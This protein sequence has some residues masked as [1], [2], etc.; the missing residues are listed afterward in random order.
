MLQLSFGRV[1]TYYSTKWVI[2]T[3]VAI[4]EIGS[5]ICAT[6]P[7]SVVLIVGR[8][9]TG[10]GGAGV[11]QGAFLLIGFLVPMEDR[12]KYLG[13]LG[14]VFGVTS[15]LGPIL[16]GYL[17]AITWRWCFW[18]NLPVGGVAI[19]LLILLTP[20]SEPPV[21]RAT[22]WKGRFLELDPLGFLLIA[23]CL[24]CLLLAVLF[25]GSKYP[26]HSGTIIALFVVSGVFGM[27][28]IVSQIW[29]GEKATVPPHVIRQRSI[30]FGCIVS[31]GIGSV[32]V[33][34]AFYL[35]IWFQVIQGKSPQS[36][37]LSLIPLLLSVVVAVI[38]SGIF[39][40]VAGYY[41]PAL[42]IGSAIL[43]VGAGLIST[44]S[45]DV[46]PRIWIRYQ[47]PFINFLYFVRD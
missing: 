3:N 33:V 24:V 14:S 10:I 28:F 5:I 32:L 20:N 34:F 2:V 26:W 35:P 42:I 38:S 31:I 18:I 19:V 23:P 21:K 43:I 40:S 17:T 1:Y 39:A 9:I 30:F 15:I 37:G 6:A 4:F 11:P 16:G 36:S 29:R 7:S 46:S 8:V 41:T 12:P 27:A 45:V 25:G 44:W 13:A 22:T 47:V